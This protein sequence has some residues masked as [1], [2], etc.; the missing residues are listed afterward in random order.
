MSIEAS[1]LQ[2]GMTLMQ[3]LQLV[4]LFPCLFL[5]ILVMNLSKNIPSAVVPA[6]YFLSLSCSFL[7][8]L[9]PLASDHL[10]V[11]LI[12]SLAETLQPA[13]CFL[14]VIQCLTT[15]PP[16]RYYWLIMALPLIGGSSLV[17]VMTIDPEVCLWRGQC[18]DTASVHVLYQMLAACFIFLMLM[19]QIGKLSS[20]YPLV[21]YKRKHTYWLMMALVGLNVCLFA[22]DLAMVAGRINSEQHGVMSSVLRISFLYLVMTSLFRVLDDLK[23]PQSDIAKNYRD[24]PVA[25]ELIEKIERLMTE[26]KLYRE[27]GFGRETMAK[28]ME[29]GEHVIS[30]AINQHFDKNFNEFVNNFRIEEAKQRLSSE[31][32]P[33][34]VIAFEVGFSSIASFNRVFKGQVGM[35]PTEYRIHQKEVPATI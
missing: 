1:A 7:I 14:M 32:T 15:N 4:G 5:T 2:V 20:Q 34:T 21:G 35:S 18:F 29:V 33:V 23:T 25:P 3:S 9:M 17:Y 24:R 13:L 19:I 10:W 28:R 30:K 11:M 26:E 16:S 27:M 8:P 12:L 6:T 31:A 22:I